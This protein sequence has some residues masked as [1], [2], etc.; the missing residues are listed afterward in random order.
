MRTITKPSSAN[1]DLN[2]YVRYLLACP[3]GSGCSQMAEI[4][5]NISHDSINRF[6]IRERYTP[7]DLFDFLVRTGKLQLIGG[8]LSGDDTLIKKPYSNIKACDLIGYYW[9][10]KAG[11]PMLGIPLV[12]LYYTCPQGF[13]V[14]TIKMMVKQRMNIYER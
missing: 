4:L 5:G 12:T 8:V 3:Q 9:S 1:C 14:S 10:S 13:T 6:L 2:F 11:K 7:K